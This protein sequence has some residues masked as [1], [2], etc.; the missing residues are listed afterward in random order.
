[1]LHETVTTVSRMITIISRSLHKDTEE[2][3]KAKEVGIGVV[4]RLRRVSTLL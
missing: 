1:V 4:S 2:F 3:S